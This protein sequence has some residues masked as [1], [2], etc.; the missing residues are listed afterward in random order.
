MS[1]NTCQRHSKCQTEIWVCPKCRKAT[2]IPLSAMASFRR[3]PTEGCGY[4]RKTAP[5]PMPCTIGQT[6]GSVVY[7]YMDERR[8]NEMRRREQERIMQQERQE[9]RRLKRWAEEEVERRVREAR[10]KKQDD[11][12]REWSVSD[13]IQHKHQMQKRKVE[14][15][16]EQKEREREEDERRKYERM[17]KKGL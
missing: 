7:R 4:V 3:C 10:A 6:W 8:E 9:R 14:V 2:E 11:L 17:M 15:L 13:H 16:A 1:I 12:K 5:T